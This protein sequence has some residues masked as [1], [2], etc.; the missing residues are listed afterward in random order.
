MR[1]KHAALSGRLHRVH[2]TATRVVGRIGAFV[3]AATRPAPVVTG[4]LTDATRSREELIAEN[5]LLRQQIIVTARATKR[6][7][8][9]P[10]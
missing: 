4:L 3:R 2:A 7:K 9:A 5:A 8:V 6:P 10:T 1:E